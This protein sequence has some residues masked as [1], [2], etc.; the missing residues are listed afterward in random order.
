MIG[1]RSV[2][3]TRW[4][5]DLMVDAC[6]IMACRHHGAA[7]DYL[8]LHAQ[9]HCSMKYYVQHKYGMS[10]DYNTFDQHPWH[11]TGQ[12]AADAA[13]WYIALSDLLIDAYHSK[14]QPW[15][16]HDPTLTLVIVKS[17]KVFINNVAM[18]V[19]G[20]T[21]KIEP[22]IQHAQTQLQWW[23]QLIQAS[24]GALNP[25]KMLLC[26]LPLALRYRWNLLSLYCQPQQH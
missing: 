10:K 12:G 6:H 23:T 16:I 4:C 5:F 8:H 26:P 22:M 15:I 11:G 13:L 7:D 17:M 9:T 21:N 1:L 3:D 19:N 24:G 18:L 25:T 14:I 20:A 2:L